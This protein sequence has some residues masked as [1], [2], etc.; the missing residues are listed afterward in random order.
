MSM[1][2][3][4]PAVPKKGKVQIDNPLGPN[5]A[6]VCRYIPALV[7]VFPSTGPGRFFTR[8]VDAIRL[9]FGDQ[10]VSWVPSG[11]ADSGLEEQ[12]IRDAR[13]LATI[14][15]LTEELSPTLRDS[16][17]SSVRSTAERLVLPTDAEI[18][19]AA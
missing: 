10:S 11:L 1:R 6:L 8:V 13:V 15:V 7:V 5:K 2:I 14:S 3:C 18:T 12:T 4:F 19:I 9:V 16:L 17:T